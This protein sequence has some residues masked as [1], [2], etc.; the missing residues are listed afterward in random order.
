MSTIDLLRTLYDHDLRGSELYNHQLVG[1]AASLINET[2]D[3]INWDQL[4]EELSGEIL[5]DLISSKRDY[6]REPSAEVA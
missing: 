6:N 2:E 1:A 4:K 5:C 3:E